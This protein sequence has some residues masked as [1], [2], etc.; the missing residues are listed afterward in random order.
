MSTA[1]GRWN[2]ISTAR[3]RSSPDI[4][5]CSL[6]SAAEAIGGVRDDGV[7]ERGA[8]RDCR[9]GLFPPPAILLALRQP[10]V[11]CARHLTLRA[12]GDID[13]DMAALERQ[14]RVVLRADVLL[15]GP[16]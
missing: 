9:P 4:R 15:Q 11:D 3:R 13:A 16:R 2:P 12:A 5:P 10:V 7:R 6:R 8:P 14:L 1:T